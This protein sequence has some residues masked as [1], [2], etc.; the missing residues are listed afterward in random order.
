MTG[1]WEPK[2][3]KVVFVRLRLGA[4]RNL[5]S[6]GEDATLFDKAL[7]V[8]ALIIFTLLWFYF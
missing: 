3:T 7:S 1:D 2:I 6:H 8:C 4:N 5:V